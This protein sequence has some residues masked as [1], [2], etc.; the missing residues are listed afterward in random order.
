MRAAGGRAVDESEGALA[1][2]LCGDRVALGEVSDHGREVR[3]RLRC[4]TE[5]HRRKIEPMVCRTCDRAAL[6]SAQR[7]ESLGQA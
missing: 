3:F 1:E 7:S 5:R 4:E 6:T 2:L